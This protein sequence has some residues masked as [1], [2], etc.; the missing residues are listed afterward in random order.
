MNKGIKIAIP[1]LLL[2]ICLSQGALSA[3]RQN[4]IDSL[5]QLISQRTGVEKTDLLNLLSRQFWQIN[6]DSSLK[7]ATQALENAQNINN[8]ASISDACNR[9]GNAYYFL[10]DTTKALE[11]YK[12][13][14]LIRKELDDAD[15]LFQIYNNLGVYYINNG[16]PEKALNNYRKAYQVSRDAHLPEN[17]AS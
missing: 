8:Q 14:L 15:R 1:F 7:Y 9:V 5:R 10:G 6:P 4:T 11:D 3:S 16:Q 13:S 2:S 17:T 12:R